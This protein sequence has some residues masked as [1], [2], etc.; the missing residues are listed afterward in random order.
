MKP[1]FIVNQSKEEFLVLQSKRNTLVRS[2][3]C[4]TFYKEKQQII[5]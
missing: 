1:Q 3:D 2:I 4:K 5:G